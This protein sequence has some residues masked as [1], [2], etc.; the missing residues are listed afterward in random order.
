MPNKIVFFNH[1]HRGDMHT[2]KE[3]IKQ[4]MRDLPDFTF[5]YLHYNP[6][7]LTNE[8][9]IKH[10]GVPDQLQHKQKFLETKDTLFINTWVGCDWDIFCKHG[11]I[12]M[13]TIHEGWEIIYDKI[14]QHFNVDLKIKD[15]KEEYLPRINYSFVDK[16]G[17]EYYINNN[18]PEGRMLICNNVPNSDQSFHGNMEEYIIPLAEENPGVH[19]ICTDKISKDLDN[20]IYTKDIIG[21]VGQTD[22]LEISYLSRFCDVIIGKNS[23]PYVFCETYDNYM[24]SDKTFISFNTKN[25]EY[26]TIKETMS[27][28]LDIK[29]KYTAVPILNNRNLTDQDKINILSAIV[30]INS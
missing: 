11:G 16:Q 22:M 24:D 19:F 26:D 8:F 23:G 10:A 6:S 13:H 7:K 25:P 20:V 28:G 12:N 5:E 1:Y 14:N 30:N 9:N 29:C 2:Q 4:V 15:S 21:D 17:I 18:E 27:N 3:Y